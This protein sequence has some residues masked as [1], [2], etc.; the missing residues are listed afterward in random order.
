MLTLYTWSPAS[1]IPPDYVSGLT[2]NIA[3]LLVIQNSW[4]MIGEINR[5]NEDLVFV[6]IELEMELAEN[7]AEV[8]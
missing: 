5:Y 3:T 7:R 2:L 6:V 8:S 4:N 1:S